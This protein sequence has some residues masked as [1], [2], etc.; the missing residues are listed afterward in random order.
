MFANWTADKAAAV[1]RLD[2]SGEALWDLAQKN[3]NDEAAHDAFLKHCSL[4][5][6]LAVAGRCYRAHLDRA[7]GDATAARMQERVVAMATLTIGTPATRDPGGMRRD[8]S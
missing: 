5:G 3:W 6:M 8:R 4:T 2:A 1:A 7:P